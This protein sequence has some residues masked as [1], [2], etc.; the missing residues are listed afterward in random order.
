ML[1]EN[2]ESVEREKK[3][4]QGGFGFSINDC[5]LWLFKELDWEAKMQYNNQYWTV[6]LDWHRKAQAF[7]LLCEGKPNVQVESV[8]NESSEVKLMGRND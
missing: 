1:V 3:K 2:V 5:P 6:L 8:K 4:R 7:D